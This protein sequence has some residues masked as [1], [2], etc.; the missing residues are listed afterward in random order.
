MVCSRSSK[1]NT[2]A[3]PERFLGDGDACH[4]ARI[5]QHTCHGLLFVTR[6]Q[7]TTKRTQRKRLYV[8]GA[9]ACSRAEPSEMNRRL[10]RSSNKHFRA[11]VARLKNQNG[12]YAARCCGWKART[13][14]VS[15]IAR[16]CFAHRGH[17]FPLSSQLLPLATF[18]FC[19]ALL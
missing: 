3:I 5:G 16:H 15:K 11:H 2:T 10:S 18:S 8:G 6:A 9:G 1:R 4:R 7:R 19:L 14:L 13:V 12:C 17:S